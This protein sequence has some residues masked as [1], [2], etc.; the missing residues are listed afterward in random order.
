MPDYSLWMK[1]IQFQWNFYVFMKYWKR[2]ALNSQKQRGGRGNWGKWI[3]SV[4]WGLKNH[5]NA[6]VVFALEFQYFFVNWVFVWSL[7]G[8]FYLYCLSNNFDWKSFRKVSLTKLSLFLWL[9]AFPLNSFLLR[10][11]IVY[12]INYFDMLSSKCQQI[13]FCVIFE[14]YLYLGNLWLFPTVPGFLKYIFIHKCVNF[15]N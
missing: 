8:Y 12:L 5:K 1:N 11:L 13:Y 10:T 3:L 4:G 2:M 15:L 7:F 6:S 9:Y 14:N